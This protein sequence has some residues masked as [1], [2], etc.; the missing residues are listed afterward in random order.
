MADEWLERAGVPA[1]ARDAY[2]DGRVDAARRLEPDALD[3]WWTLL[4]ERD[5]VE[6]TV[7]PVWLT[8]DE[9]A[10]GSGL[11]VVVTRDGRPSVE[12]ETR[13]DVAESLRAWGGMEL[14]NRATLLPPAKRS[15]YVA[16]HHLIDVLSGP[17]RDVRRA[18]YLIHEAEHHALTFGAFLPGDVEHR[19]LLLRALALADAWVDHHRASVV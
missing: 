12:S 8:R 2:Y 9:D 15:A 10:D 18:R 7:T 16:C 6:W 11:G 1:W 4:D 13:H 19:I 5:G 14:G 17:V 3:G